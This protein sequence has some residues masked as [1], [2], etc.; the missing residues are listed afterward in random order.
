MAEQ[1]KEV[2]KDVEKRMKAAINVLKGELSHVK[3]GRATPAL[4][5]NISVDYYGSVAELKTISSISTPDAKTILIQPW[6]KNALQPIEKAIWKSDLGFNP[7]VDANLIRIN[8]PPLT[9]ERR[10]EIAKF[11]KKSVEEAK[12]AIR[13][14]RREANDTIKRLEKEGIVPEDESKKTVADVQKL[15]DE[16]TNEIDGVWEKKEKEILNI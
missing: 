2:L 16:C 14:I 12:V 13:N 6:D 8:V 4:I 5:E 7:V 11:T 3:T 9:E 15:T 1:I 10:K